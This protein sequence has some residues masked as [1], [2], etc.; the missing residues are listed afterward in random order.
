MEFNIDELLEQGGVHAPL[1]LASAMTMTSS[2]TTTLAPSLVTDTVTTSL[3]GNT[4]TTSLVTDTVTTSLV[5]NT[6]T[7]SLVT[8]TVTT[9]LQCGGSDSCDDSK[10]QHPVSDEDMAKMQRRFSK[11]ALDFMNYAVKI[12]RK[13]KDVS[14]SYYPIL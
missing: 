13:P 1:S 10:P 12:T 9:W 14:I 5:A 2:T 8:D 11:D 7:T 3:V 4:V 6:L